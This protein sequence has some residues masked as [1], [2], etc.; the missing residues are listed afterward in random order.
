ML[1]RVFEPYY[2]TKD[3]G[4]GLGLPIAK[5]IVEDHGGSIRI[6]SEPSRGTTVVL[7]LPRPKA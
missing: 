6:D 4:T 7:R 3:V 2:S 1:D 5:K